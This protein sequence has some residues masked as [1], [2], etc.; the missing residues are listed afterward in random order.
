MTSWSG[1]ETYV[2]YASELMLITV[3]GIPQP[4]AHYLLEQE[5]YIDDRGEQGV[6]SRW[7]PVLGRYLVLLK[8]GYDFAVDRGNKHWQSLEKAKELR[9]YYAHLDV[10]E[11]RAVSSQDVLDYM[12][13]VMMALIWPS[14]ELRRTLL[15]GVY[16]LYEMWAELRELQS[17]Y[18]EQP[19]FKDWPG[20]RPYLFHCNFEN[21]DILRF[22]NPEELRRRRNGA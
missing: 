16:R 10:H 7:Q 17:E 3:K 9:D 19:W 2:R 20:E 18:I 15:L 22:P 6:R 8:H 21:V 12:E 13:A 1:F 5:V 11:P 14:C 4:V